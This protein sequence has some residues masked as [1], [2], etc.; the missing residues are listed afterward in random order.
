MWYSLIH[1][2]CLALKK[3]TQVV[4]T[5][6]RAE[7]NVLL[8]CPEKDSSQKKSKAKQRLPSKGHLYLDLFFC[9][10]YIAGHFRRKFC[11]ALQKIVNTWKIFQKLTS[12]RGLELPPCSKFTR[13]TSQSENI[14]CKTFYTFHI[15]IGIWMEEKILCTTKYPLVQWPNS[16]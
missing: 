9:L 7:K 14:E 10:E 3:I 6:C 2:H 15:S 12:E 16:F 4:R 1:G 5:F 13:W 8:K 11:S